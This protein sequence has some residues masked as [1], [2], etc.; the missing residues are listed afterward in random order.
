[1]GRPLNEALYVII[2]FMVDRKHLRHKEERGSRG[3]KEQTS[4]LAETE[5]RNQPSGHI[6]TMY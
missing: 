3:K 4:H 1:M 6:V 5:A 2:C